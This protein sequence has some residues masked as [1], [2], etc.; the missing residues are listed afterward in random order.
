MFRGTGGSG[1]DGSVLDLQPIRIG[2]W[3]GTWNERCN[4]VIMDNGT[5]GTARLIIFRF[6]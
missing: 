5:R 2:T 3:I 6:L 4:L 1:S